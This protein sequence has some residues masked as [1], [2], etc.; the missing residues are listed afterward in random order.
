MSLG[1]VLIG[2]SFDRK[3]EEYKRQDQQASS[4]LETWFECGCLKMCSL[5]MSLSLCSGGYQSSECEGGGCVC[6]GG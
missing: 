3:C 2:S 5:L 4:F 1:E 6:V